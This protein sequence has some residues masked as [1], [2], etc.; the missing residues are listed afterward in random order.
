MFDIL[1]DLAVSVGDLCA[2]RAL[3][4]S[5]LR[6]KWIRSGWFWSD[7]GAWLRA[8]CAEKWSDFRAERIALRD[9]C[10]EAHS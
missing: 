6:D 1:A 2:Y 4:H 9:Q 10:R 3:R 7:A 8:R 5:Q